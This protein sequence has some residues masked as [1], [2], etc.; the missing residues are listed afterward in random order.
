MGRPKGSTNS[1]TSK[2]V[3]KNVITDES[4][5]STQPE[6]KIYCLKCGCGNQNNFYLC[7][8]IPYDILKYV[9]E[10]IVKCKRRQIPYIFYSFINSTFSP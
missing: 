5:L 2:V 1:K 6:K 3:K 8:I 7:Y 10:L 4:K 9:Q